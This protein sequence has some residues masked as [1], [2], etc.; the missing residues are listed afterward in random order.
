MKKVFLFIF[1][2][3]TLC[4][5]LATA[6]NPQTNSVLAET[7][8]SIKT[9]YYG[10]DLSIDY[11]TKH[12]TGNCRMTIKNNGDKTLDQVPLLL[13]RLMTIDAI[14]TA[15]GMEMSFS[16]QVL[17]FLDWPQFQANYIIVTLP[18]PLK[19]DRTTTLHIDYNGYLL[20]YGETGMLYVKDSV[21]DKF[22]I[23]RPDSKAYPQ[24]GYPSWKVNRKAGPQRF[25]YDVR[26]T[27]PQ[28][29]V[30]AN[31]GRL[32][33][34]TV[35]DG[36]AT[37]SYKNIKPAW[38]IDIAVADYKVVSGGAKGNLKVFCFDKHQSG[39]RKIMQAME[40]AKTLFTGW[41]GPLKGANE[42]AVIELPSGYG[43]QTDV[44]AI[45]QVEEAFA[46]DAEMKQFYH[47]VSHLWNV[48]MLDPLPCR[49]ESEGLAMFLQFLAQEKLE[50]KQNVLYDVFPKYVERVAKTLEKKQEIMNIP[51]MD[52]G[53]NGI[54]GLSYSKGLLFF[55]ILYE[56][57][58]ERQFMTIIKNFYHKYADGATT[59]QFVNHLNAYKNFSLSKLTADWI[60]HTQS[61]QYLLQQPSLNTLTAK[62]RN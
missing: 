50:G 52:H 46:D 33:G 41:F 15:K 61:N 13:Y 54:T 37:Y 57:V 25:D 1:V 34:K 5:T 58:G 53:K 3:I 24:V 2:L 12:I 29:K 26:V 27:V 32:A 16:Q 49:F 62:Y 14:K 22:T 21:D 8:A 11:K 43:S 19:K 9:F 31:G 30:V 51:M 45:L 56:L 36:K 18:V 55:T 17:S 44:T 10:L 35:K 39:A 20:G 38:R 40:K 59:Q 4:P 47:E 23:I 7:V 48:R 60:T 42:F 6:T 28:N